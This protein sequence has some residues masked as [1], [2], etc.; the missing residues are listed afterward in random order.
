MMDSSRD[1]SVAC[2]LRDRLD[3]LAPRRAD[4]APAPMRVPHRVVWGRLGAMKALSRGAWAPVD[5]VLLKPDVVPPEAEKVLLLFPAE[6]IPGSN[7]TAATLAK[8][9][10]QCPFLDDAHVPVGGYGSV[11]T[12]LN[13]TNMSQPRLVNWSV[14]VQPKGDD[15]LPEAGHV[16]LHAYPQLNRPSL[17]D[18]RCR[19]WPPAL[20]DLAVYVHK[21]AFPYLGPVSKV[22]PYNYCECKLY[23]SLFNSKIGRHRDAFRSS[24]LVDYY[25]CGR[26]P[27]ESSC[28]QMT[29]SDVCIWSLGT[30]VLDLKLYFPRGRDKANTSSNDNYVTDPAFHCPLLGG[31]LFVF[32][33]LDDFFFAHEGELRSPPVCCGEPSTWRAAL[34]FRCISQDTEFKVDSTHARVMT[35]EERKREED[36]RQYVVKKKQRKR[37][38]GY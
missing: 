36:K 13:K 26:S 14:K 34:V 9:L 16:R 32:K 8:R 38:R 10:G 24:Q 31:H 27:F 5:S 37:A 2:S 7:D 11:W 15:V 3:S 4:E 29:G 33:C 18:L 35:T 12:R 25:E 22:T 6:V 19:E 20:S 17:A 21:L 28:A 23:Y 30:G 1:P